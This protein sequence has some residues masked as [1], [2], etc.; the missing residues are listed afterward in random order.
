MIVGIEERRHGPSDAM[1][2]PSQ[3]FEFLSKETCGSLLRPPSTKTKAHKSSLEPEEIIVINLIRT[4]CQDTLVE[5]HKVHEIDEWKSFQ[6]QHQTALR[7]YALSWK[8]CQG[9]SLNL[10]DH[11]YKRRCCSPIPAKSDSLSHAHTQASKVNHSTSRLLILNFPI[12]K[13]PQRQIKNHQLG[14]IVSLMI[15]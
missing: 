11:R 6:S 9:D 2:N 13:D 3:P 7:S 10:P 5:H 1:H 8:P 12:I 15:I 14:K 4:Q